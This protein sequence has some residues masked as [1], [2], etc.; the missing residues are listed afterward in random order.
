MKFYLAYGSN[1]SVEQML[2]RCPDAVYVGKTVIPGHR[3]LF[4]GSKTGSYLTVEPM[5]GRHVPALVWLVSR[6]DEKALDRYEGFPDF[7]QKEE[8]DVT[9]CSLI[10]GEP[11]GVVR[12][13]VYKMDASNPLGMPSARYYQ[14]CSEGYKRFGFEQRILEKAF[15]E[16]IDNT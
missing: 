2:R 14:V 7:Y 15:F 11:I 8:M 1:L 9:V 13:F 6:S 12:A 4:R 10:D 3:L 16:S 5:N